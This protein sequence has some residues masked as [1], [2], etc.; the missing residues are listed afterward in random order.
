LVT[1]VRKS[2]CIDARL[3]NSES[4]VDVNPMRTNPW[5]EPLQRIWETSKKNARGIFIGTAIVCFLFVVLV[6]SLRMGF[7]VTNHNKVTLRFVLPNDLAAQWQAAIEEF[8]T[9]YPHI[10]IDLV[11]LRD[12]N[13]IKPYDTKATKKQYVDSFMSTNQPYDLVYMDVIWVPEFA[14]QHWIQALPMRTTDP[15]LKQF[16][17]DDVR[18]GIYQNK[19]YRMPVHSNMGLLYYRADMLQKA[20]LSPPQTFQDLMDVSR[21]LQ[22]QGVRWGYLWQGGQIESISAMF[23]EVLH[24]HGGFWINPDTLDVGLDH[25]E[26]ITAVQFLYRTMF[27]DNPISPKTL[28][29]YREEETRRAFLD[30]NAVFLRNWSNVLSLETQTGFVIQNRIG[31]QP[32]VHA[33][34]FTGASCQ[35][36]WGLGIAQRTQHPKEAWQAV[37]FFSS[38]TAQ[39]KLFLFGNIGLPTRRELYRDPQLVKRYPYYPAILNFLDNQTSHPI[40]HRPAIPEY[41]QASCLLQK[42]L[43]TILSQENSDIDRKMQELARDTRILLRKQAGTPTEKSCF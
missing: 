20:G 40:V 5:H 21:Q 42:Y 14:A 27:A 24:G 7:N 33:P 30:G 25:P 26:A 6:W 15:E 28:T 22:A 23:M 41:A 4:I 13:A 36:G 16:L 18:G 10:D 39:R 32:M 8:E 35:G 37:Q 43:H 34:G 3:I 29:T 12:Q 38:A 2:A 11:N 31:V 9:T 1:A 17:R 19:L